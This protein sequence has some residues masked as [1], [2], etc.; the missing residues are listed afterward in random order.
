MSR[1]NPFS[2]LVIATC[3]VLCGAF[4]APAQVV[5]P[6][7]CGDKPPVRPIDKSCLGCNGPSRGVV[8]LYRA[9]LLV[10]YQEMAYID[11]FVAM[12][13]CSDTVQA[14]LKDVQTK[15][16]AVGADA[17]IRVRL[18]NNKV[19]GF[20]EDPNTP[21]FSVRQG[22]SRDY[23]FRGT[24]VRYLEPV[25]GEPEEATMVQAPTRIPVATRDRRGGFLGST[26][27]FTGGRNL[28]NDRNIERSTP[29]NF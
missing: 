28:G 13:N 3:F 18:L 22:E 25:Q 8:P 21:F 15:A 16:R 23:F 5:D 14:Q 20:Q 19:R 1:R 24:A 6:E 2:E 9:D 10:K 12:D 26:G 7:C 4:G 29:F 11:S 17:V 27:R